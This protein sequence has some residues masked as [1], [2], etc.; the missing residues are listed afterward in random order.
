MDRNPEIPL[1]DEN[2]LMYLEGYRTFLSEDQRYFSFVEEVLPEDYNG[3]IKYIQMDYKYELRK[4]NSKVL[5][6]FSR[7]LDTYKKTYSNK[8]LKKYDNSLHQ[9]RAESIQEMKASIENIMEILS[10]YRQEEVRFTIMQRIKQQVSEK[11]LL[12][13][14][15][16]K[17][18]EESEAQLSKAK[19]MFESSTGEKRK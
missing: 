10:A 1:Q 3:H 16:K 5:T 19:E 11:K 2:S 18:R 8:I 12:I 14:Q 9:S 17:A 13:E 6:A 7:L 4:M 15:L